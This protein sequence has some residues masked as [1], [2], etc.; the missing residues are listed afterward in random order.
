MGRGFDQA[1]PNIRFVF[2]L[3][4]PSGGYLKLHILEWLTTFRAL[5]LLLLIAG[6]VYFI[7][8]IRRGSPRRKKRRDGVEFRPSIG[9][10]WQDGF[11]SVALLLANKSEI[12]VWA[13]EI[14]IGLTGTV[15]DQQTSEATCHEVHKILQYVGADDVLPIS[16]VETIYTAAGKPQRKYSCVMSSVVRYRIGEELVVESLPAYGL[17]MVGLTVAG[18]RRERK[19][20]YEFKTQGHFRELPSGSATSK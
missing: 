16:L 9:F 13:E 5:V 11:Q 6:L 14:E 8:R 10:A 17:R 1:L 2:W 3:L 4:R 7:A 20:A 19:S 18:V 15:A 12:P